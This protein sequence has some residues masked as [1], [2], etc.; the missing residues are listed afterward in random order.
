MLGWWWV[1]WTCTRRVTVVR[2]NDRWSYGE[3]LVAF[4]A[5]GTY[6]ARRH[7]CKHPSVYKDYPPTKK[8]W[9]QC[10]ALQSIV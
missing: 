8:Q 10:G 3:M 1:A 4:I 6:C 9:T 2:K 5:S 7:K